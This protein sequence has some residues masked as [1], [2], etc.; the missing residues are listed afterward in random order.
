MTDI[1]NPYTAQ[2]E[3]AIN[4]M[5]VEATTPALQENR[6]LRFML[7]LLIGGMA[8]GDIVSP[9]EIL[10]HF[11]EKSARCQVWK[12]D[13][14]PADLMFTAGVNFHSAGS[15]NEAIAQA[16]IKLELTEQGHD[17]LKAM[18]QALRNQLE[19]FFVRELGKNFVDANGLNLN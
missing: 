11:Y 18:L 16:P 4:R 3:A 14:I 6:R 13:T 2:T 10:D 12:K 1:N 8:E 19:T 7:G 9:E 17:E 15:G 5:I